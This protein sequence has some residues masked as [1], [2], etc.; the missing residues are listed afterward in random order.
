MN[1]SF[2]KRG[3]E[4]KRAIQKICLGCCFLRGWGSGLSGEGSLCVLGEAQEERAG[5]A[6]LETVKPFI[7][8]GPGCLSPSPGGR[9][10][11]T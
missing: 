5:A 10:S 7:K 3:L 9:G 4:L 1:F 6:Q 11:C 8:V 2:Q